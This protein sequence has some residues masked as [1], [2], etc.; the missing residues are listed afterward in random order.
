MWLIILLVCPLVLLLLHYFT[1]PW[2][3]S[4][5][6]RTFLRGPLGLRKPAHRDLKEHAI[7]HLD[8]Q[9]HTF[10]DY[11]KTVNRDMRRNLTTNIAKSFLTHD[12]VAKSVSG[13][14][15]GRRHFWVV[16]DH[17]LRVVGNRALAAIAALGRCWAF[18]FTCWGGMDEIYVRTEVLERLQ[19]GKM[20]VSCVVRSVNFGIW[21]FFFFSPFFFFFF[22]SWK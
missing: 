15:F 14:E 10:E 6:K 17:Q 22:L 18:W 2:T 16:Y 1:A 11:L 21:G 4:W 12:I 13:K 5:R 9:I 19:R 7:L 8:P 20:M 3:E